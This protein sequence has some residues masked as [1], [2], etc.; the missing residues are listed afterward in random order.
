M[1]GMAIMACF[2]IYILLFLIVGIAGL[3]AQNKTYLLIGLAILIAPIVKFTWDIPI[4][5]FQYK[6]LS[7]QEA[8]LKIY[9][10][11]PKPA[12]RIRLD[13]GSLSEHDAELYLKQYPSLQQ[14]EAKDRK[15]NNTHDPAAYA[16]YESNIKG[17]VV[18]K[19]MDTVDKAGTP[20]VT[21]S[22]PS[23]AEYFLSVEKKHYKFDVD[24]E[25]YTLR[26]ADN[27]IIATVT[28]ITSY[29]PLIFDTWPLYI[30]ENGNNNYKELIK[31]IAPAV[32]K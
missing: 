13:M 21:Y 17:K 26:S 30:K 18:S 5:Y 10:N 19:L 32:P 20:K 3:K 11:N 2:V 15:L 8:G 9:V 27:V 31:L 1:I 23:Q 7:I 25:R 4:R 12:K 28:K 22:A 14:I 29:G 6:Q 24:M 16:L